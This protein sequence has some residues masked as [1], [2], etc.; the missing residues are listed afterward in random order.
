MD[1]FATEYFHLDAFFGIERVP[2]HNGCFR[3]LI[4]KSYGSVVTDEIVGFGNA[5]EVIAQ[6]VL[7]EIDAPAYDRISFLVHGFEI[8]VLG[9]VNVAFDESYRILDAFEFHGT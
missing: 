4:Q 9:N 2:F 8:S 6:F 3:K 1:A 5:F 7:D